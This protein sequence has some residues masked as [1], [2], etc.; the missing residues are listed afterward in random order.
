MTYTIPNST[1]PMNY[2][3]Q[4]ST[5]VPI[6]MPL[7]LFLIW[8][9]VLG[10]GYFSQERRTGRGNITMWAAISG[11]MSTTI[12][13]ILFLIPGLISLEVVVIFVIISILSTIGFFFNSKN[14]DEL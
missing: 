6:L 4:L 2:L 14:Q 12:A 3:V 10:A 5:Q 7:L 11:Y 9:V 1:D 8:L 13:F